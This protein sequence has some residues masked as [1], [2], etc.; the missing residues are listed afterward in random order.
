MKNRNERELQR[1]VLAIVG[2]LV[3][4]SAARVRGAIGLDDTRDRDRRIGSLERVELLLRIGRAIGTDSADG[5][6]VRGPAF[7]FRPCGSS[8]SG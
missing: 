2:G 5:R 8:C 7:P 6:N 4:G 3:K 1:G